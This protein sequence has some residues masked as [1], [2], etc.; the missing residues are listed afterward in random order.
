MA[1]SF[2]MMGFQVQRELEAE[3]AAAAEEASRAQAAIEAKLAELR[4]IEAAR[5][6][7]V[8]LFCPAWGAVSS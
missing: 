7:E 6:Q 5:R 2:V 3:R 8:S 1:E 4:A